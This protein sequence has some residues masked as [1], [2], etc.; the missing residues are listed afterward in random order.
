MVSMMVWNMD[1]GS[2]VCRSRRGK[3]KYDLAFV[4]VVVLDNP[5]TALMPNG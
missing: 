3:P 5:N 4:T 2:K 1:N